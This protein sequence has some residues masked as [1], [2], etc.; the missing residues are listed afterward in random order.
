M[1]KERLQKE[2]QGLQARL[3][4]VHIGEEAK[5]TYRKRIEYLKEKIKELESE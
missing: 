2:I 1:T 4:W 5:D 3:R